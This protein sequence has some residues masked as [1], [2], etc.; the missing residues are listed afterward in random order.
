M[1]KAWEK[2][3]HH[4][5]RCWHFFW[6]SDSGW[7]WLANIVVAFVVIRVIGYPLLGVLLGTPFPIVAVVSE[8]MEH[9]ID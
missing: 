2:I 7:S 1:G 8:S 4:R 5:K 3:H 9:T 6:H